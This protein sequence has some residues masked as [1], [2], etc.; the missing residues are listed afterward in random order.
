MGETVVTV[1]FSEVEGGTEVTVSQEGFP[2]NEAKVAHEEG[3]S[4]CLDHFE[5]LFA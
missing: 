2:A 1:K 3:W 4:A 5:G